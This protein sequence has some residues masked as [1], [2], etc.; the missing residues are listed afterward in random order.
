MIYILNGHIATYIAIASYIV[1]F[2]YSLHG[3]L[4]QRASF[5]DKDMEYDKLTED[6]RLNL[7]Q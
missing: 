1:L 3:L 2:L 6:I 4:L 7:Y 5:S